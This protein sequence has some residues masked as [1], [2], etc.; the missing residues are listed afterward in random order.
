[1]PG[2]K[3][4]NAPFHK[5]T[6][7]S[8]SFETSLSI[9]DIEDVKTEFIWF[10]NGENNAQKL[11]RQFNYSFLAALYQKYIDEIEKLKTHYGLSEIINDCEYAHGWF[12][13]WKKLRIYTKEQ[14]LEKIKSDSAFSE[15]WGEMG[16]SDSLEFRRWGVQVQFDANDSASIKNPGKDQLNQL[17]G[18]LSLK[19][20][21]GMH[22]FSLFNP[23]NADERISAMN[24]L[25]SQFDCIELSFEERA[26]WFYEK[27][28][29]NSIEIAQEDVIAKM[30]M[31]N[32]EKINYGDTFISIPKYKLNLLS[33]FNGF[34]SQD[35]LE[36]AE[37]FCFFLMAVMSKIMNMVPGYVAL[38]S[39]RTPIQRGKKIK[40][41]IS[42]VF[43][44]VIQND[45]ILDY[46]HIKIKMN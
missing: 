3:K 6:Q 31:G 9:E 44:Q 25:I 28:I 26:K 15:V 32:L 5:I 13:D 14:F 24:M 29:E 39:A 34:Y 41:R 11:F 17:I 7:F 23:S 36:R 2:K 19:P 10:F 20:K 43:D 30:K 18:S 8:D 40:K 16:V 37:C 1:M 45:L 27:H 21:D 22:A 33:T 35:H 42:V 46:N 38:S 4:K 12:E